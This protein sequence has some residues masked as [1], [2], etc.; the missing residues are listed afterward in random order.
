MG[1]G[2][3]QPP[4]G[5]GIYDPSLSDQYPDLGPSVLPTEE[6]PS[7]E[8]G[9]PL[10]QQQE[11]IE[12][13]TAELA[14]L[15]EQELQQAEEAIAESN[16][17]KLRELEERTQ[18]LEIENQA[19]ALEG[20]AQEQ[21]NLQYLESH[22]GGELLRATR[23]APEGFFKNMTP[24]QREE[25]FNL[26]YVRRNAITVENRLL[27]DQAI[28]DWAKAEGFPMIVSPN[29]G[30]PTQ[31]D[32]ISPMGAAAQRK[33]LRF[34]ELPVDQQ[35][36][37]LR[38]AIDIGPPGYRPPTEE[39]LQEPLDEN[40]GQEESGEYEESGEVE[41]ES[42]Q[43]VQ[44]PIGDCFYHKSTKLNTRTYSLSEL[45]VKLNAALRRYQNNVEKEL[46][47]P[48]AFHSN[49]L[50][51]DLDHVLLSSCIHFYKD[52]VPSHAVI[53]ICGEIHNWLYSTLTRVCDEYEGCWRLAAHFEE[54][55]QQKCKLLMQW[56]VLD[57]CLPKLQK[58]SIDSIYRQYYDLDATEEFCQQ[59]ERIK[60]V[61][62][63]NQ[64]AFVSLFNQ[65]DFVFSH[66]CNEK[67]CTSQSINNLARLCCKYKF[68]FEFDY[69]KT[70]L[71]SRVQRRLQIGS[72]EGLSSEQQPPSYIMESIYDP[73]RQRYSP[74]HRRT[75]WR[76]PLVGLDPTIR[77]A[78]GDFF[79]TQLVSAD[80]RRAPKSK[81]EGT[82][83]CRATSRSWDSR[84][85]DIS[86]RSSSSSRACLC[87]DRMPTS[88]SIG[89]YVL[90][91]H[92]GH[93][94]LPRRVQ[95]LGSTPQAW[96]TSC[97]W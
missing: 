63:T 15:R 91:M 64:K 7:Y 24:K 90:E 67:T 28:N 66:C 49:G 11:E 31:R 69:V 23:Q 68:P 56:L 93:N 55:L 3:V 32:L 89:C 47:M 84:L 14:P 22:N 92:R 40:G 83:L 36:E 8:Q 1:Y 65:V 82:P 38:K 57:R 94:R 80:Q 76:R 97:G 45:I 2:N 21:E 52:S 17:Q 51:T 86:R 78:S 60:A 75:R 87:R 35:I 72:K 48:L 81:N 61:L 30:P 71:P 26:A 37:Q 25:L 12:R 54:L 13:E 4:P 96:N 44:S 10:L 29:A 20:V 50:R 43:A 95:P 9:D 5:S 42:G 39:A 19:K 34:R 73:H 27:A 77:R 79:R 74:K 88:I 46:D 70:K 62:S 53:A 41:D 85:R 16:E 33:P 59:I 58:F 18:R 6:Y